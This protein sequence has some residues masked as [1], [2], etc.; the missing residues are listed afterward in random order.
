MRPK[1][2]NLPNKLKIWKFINKYLQKN[3]KSP[4]YREIAKFMKFRHR[5]QCEGYIKMLK[6][7]GKLTAIPGKKRSLQII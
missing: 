3:N 4:T 6:A 2:E 1:N 5:Q 7:E